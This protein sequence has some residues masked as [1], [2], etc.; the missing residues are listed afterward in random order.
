MTT[1]PQPTALNQARMTLPTPQPQSPPRGMLS[2]SLM[3]SVLALV[4]WLAISPA[5]SAYLARIF[6]IRD[7]QV[8]LKRDGWSTFQTAHPGTALYGDDLLRVEP[9]AVVVLVC[10]DRTPTNS[11]PAGDS[12]VSRACP[13]T[14]RRVR[15]T[16]GISDSWSAEDATLPYVITPWSGQVLTPTPPLR[17]HPVEGAPLY[18]ITL[19]QRTGDRWEDV[20]TVRSD[21]PHLAYPINQPGLQFGEEYA[22][23]I[24]A[25][26]NADLPQ[27]DASPE[28]FSLVGGAE[29]ADAEDEIA[30]VNTMD[31]P[32]VVKTLILVEEVYP[33]YK[34]F[35]QGISDLLGLIEEGT[36]TA[37]IYRLLG[38]YYISSGLELP[39][40]TSYLKALELAEASEN[41]EEQVK[42][43]WGLGTLYSRVNKPDQALEYL[44]QA[45]QGAI[46]LGDGDL[47]TSIEAELDKLDAE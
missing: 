14:P 2:R 33:T 28:V 27:A 20:W 36:E 26:A 25:D 46:T 35:P 4:G 31:A 39:T 22:L 9:G 43:L 5:A 42:A 1:S 38:D 24:L 13:E 18:T 41:L 23:R 45:Q 16:F 40:E 15:P 12:S 32:Q 34:L 3:I 19:K 17:W 29:R 21:Q 10:P 47:L 44:V 37:Q 7:G 30:A 6:S 8:Q 11:V